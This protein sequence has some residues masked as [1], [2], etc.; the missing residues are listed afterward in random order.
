MLEF[1]KRLVQWVHKR[2]RIGNITQPNKET[3]N[4]TE[5]CAYEFVTEEYLQQKILNLRLSTTKIFS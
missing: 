2:T 3:N 5:L 1:E 4:K